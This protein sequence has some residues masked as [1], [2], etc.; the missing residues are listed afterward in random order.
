M[1]AI[2][3]PWADRGTAV[4]VHARRIEQEW[5]LLAIPLGWFAAV[6]H[7]ARRFILNIS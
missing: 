5:H 7:L 6:A 2:L 1:S 4:A 3:V